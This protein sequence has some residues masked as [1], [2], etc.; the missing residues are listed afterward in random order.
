MAT[1]P[2]RPPPPPPAPISLSVSPAYPGTPKR[3]V[4]PVSTTRRSEEDVDEWD[5]YD[6]PQDP[7]N[8]A[9]TPS[10]TDSPHGF[11]NFSSASIPAPETRMVLA[12]DYGTTFTGVAYLSVASRQKD[13]DLDVLADD[14]R[15]L[16]GWPTHESEKVPSEISYSPSPKGC[17]QWGYDIDDNSRVLKWTKLELEE[18]RNRS[19]ELTTLAETL[20]GMRLLDLSEEAVIRNDIPRHLAKEPEDIVKDYLDHIAEQTLEEIQTQVGRKV[21]DNI[22]IDMVI[23][24]PAKWSDK[25]LNSTYRAV[26]LAF[27]PGLFPKIRNFSFVSE[28]E[29]CAHYT[30]REAMREDRVNFRKN[31]C[32]IVVDAGGGTVDLAS[33]KVVSLDLD[34]KQFK[35]EQIGYPIG[36]KCGATC[37]DRAFEEFIRLKVGP[38]DWEKLMETESQDTATGG[39]SIIKP[40]LRMLH[41]RFEG[42]KHQFDG[43]DQKLGFPIQLPRGIGTTDDEERGIMNGAIKITVD[44][45]KQMFEHS[46]HKTLVLIGQAATH[47]Q[48]AKKL[49][50]RKIFLSGGFGRSP[51][52]YERVKHWGATSGIQ[53]DRGDDCWSAVTRGAI[54]KS[55]GVHTDLPPVIRPCPRHYGIKVR[56]QYA[57]YESH[58]PSDLDV[59]PEGVSWATDQIRWFVNKGDAIFPGKP[60]ISTYDCHWSMK[61]SHFHAPPNGTGTGTA[62]G[63][64]AGPSHNFGGSF[65]NRFDKRGGAVSNNMAPPPPPPDVFR[66]VVFV[67][68]SAEEPPTRFGAVNKGRDQTVTLKCNLTKI[69][70]KNRTKFVNKDFG[71]YYKF[72]VKV[73]IHVTEKCEVKITSDGKVLASAEVPLGE[74]DMS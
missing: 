27:E 4:S 67:A 49:K 53:V 58:K 16:Q 17:R 30:L 64:R 25:A 71:E 44:D 74:S 40:K 14:I 7:M 33:Y 50:V 52:L 31:D 34:K 54:I 45:L 66:E 21:A 22:P 3:E 61:A 63:A 2:S 32:F 69:P 72:M 8:E 48:I 68:S 12:L 19:A 10:R 6:D 41:G 46:V 18:I 11:S 57:P 9:I 1:L 59:D 55:L 26:R 35:L 62:A 42:I 13:Q 24:H 38:E 51:Y 5:N 56:M 23:T 15:V 73:E 70:D 43:K 65:S 29:A 39:H 60:L 20:W 36:D 47:I 28:P 37:I